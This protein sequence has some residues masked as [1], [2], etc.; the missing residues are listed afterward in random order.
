MKIVFVSNFYNHHQSALSDALYWLTDGNYFFV[1]TSEMP[2]EQRKLG[3]GQESIPDYVL[4][5]YRSIESC[6]RCRQVINEADVVIAGSAPEYLLRERIQ[7]GK[8][9]FRYSERPLKKGLEPIKYLPRLLR[10]HARSPMYKP[11]YMLCASAYTA[12]DYAKFGLFRNRCYKWGYFPE[13]KRYDEEDLFAFKQ[14]EVPK[15]L[16]VGRFLEWKHADHV[17]LIAERLK[18]AGYRFE[19]NFIGMGELE[20]QLAQMIR[21]R[22]LENCVHLLGAMPPEQVRKHMERANIYLFTSDR[23]EG[24]GAVLNESMNSGC[25]VVASH[26]IGSVPF[27]MKDGENGLVYE[28]GNVDM[29]F[30]KV[31]HLLDHP[32]EQ[33]RLGRAAYHTAIEEWNAEVAAKR[34]ILLSECLLR[35]EKSPNL[36]ES[37]SC[38]KAKILKD[39]YDQNASGK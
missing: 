15:I 39:K 19:L 36:F 37:G 26:A 13:T 16:W 21:E 27:L 2:E 20:S 32:E 38:S 9:M 11:I 24:W 30:R 12:A 7:T 5:S 8:L 4:Y 22:G 34:L 28:S 17:V 33:R 31:K 14:N 1:A 10:W 3:Y 35:G 29:L 18:N 6:E 23:N 25:A